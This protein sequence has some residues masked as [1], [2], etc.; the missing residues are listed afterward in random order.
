[1]C[2]A[3]DKTQSDRGIANVLRSNL[4]HNVIRIV[5]VDEIVAIA[6]P[7]CFGNKHICEIGYESVDCRFISTVLSEKAFATIGFRQPGRQ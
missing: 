1:M 3:S 5:A 4:R 7:T 2:T 6:Y